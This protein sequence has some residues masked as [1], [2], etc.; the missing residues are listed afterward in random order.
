MLRPLWL[1]TGSGR[2]VGLV[3][4]FTPGFGRAFLSGRLLVFCGGIFAGTPAARGLFG[5]RRRYR[6]FRWG[7]FARRCRHFCRFGNCA[8]GTRLLCLGGPARPG[9]VGTRWRFGRRLVRPGRRRFTHRCCRFIS[10]RRWIFPSGCRGLFPLCSRFAPTPGTGGRLP[11]LGLR[12]RGC[13]G[14]HGGLVQ[15]FNSFCRHC[16]PFYSLHNL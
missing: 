14:L 9:P 7:A 3:V 8:A 13:G 2:A 4:T 15:R 11:V 5:I 12:L 16:R 1:K 6:A 10:G